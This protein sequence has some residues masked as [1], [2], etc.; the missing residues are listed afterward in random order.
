[1]GYEDDDEVTRRAGDTP[2]V[3]PALLARPDVRA[4]LAGHDIGAFYRVLG[5]NGWTQ[6]EIAPPRVACRCRNRR[7]GP[8]I[9]GH[10]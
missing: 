8:A 4:A 6:R 3:D 9:A 2:P 10:W 1:M 7:G 5:D